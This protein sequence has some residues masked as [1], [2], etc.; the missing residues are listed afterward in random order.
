MS[1]V[2]VLAA[3]SSVFADSTYSALSKALLKNE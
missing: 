1:I 3:L 2:F